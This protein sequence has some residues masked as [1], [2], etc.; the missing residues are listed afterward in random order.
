MSGFITGK[1]RTQ[2]AFFPE[3]LDDSDSEDNAIRVGY[4]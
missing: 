4:N 1:A 3:Q 2:V